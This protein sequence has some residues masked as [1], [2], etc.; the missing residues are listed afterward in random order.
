[1]RL[2]CSMI[3]PRGRWELVLNNGRRHREEKRHS[4]WRNWT[5]K[6]DSWQRTQSGLGRRKPA[7]QTGPWSHP[8]PK[9][10]QQEPV[11]RPD[12]HHHSPVKK[13]P[14]RQWMSEN[15]EG[16]PAPAATKAAAVKQRIKAKATRPATIEA[17]ERAAVGSGAGEEQTSTQQPSSG[18]GSCSFT[19]R[20]L[21][22]SPLP[23]PLPL[24]PFHFSTPPRSRFRF[25]AT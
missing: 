11:N 1:M 22:P 18:G 3:F 17:S 23:L 15:N 24:T 4:C 25:L 6:N 2:R 16:W 7:T 9:A 14:T 20:R 10:A 12:H 13:T 21:S 5:K 8:N 19:S